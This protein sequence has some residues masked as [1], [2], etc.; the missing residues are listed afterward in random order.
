MNEKIERA[1]NK[2]REDSKNII[3]NMIAGVETKIVYVNGKEYFLNDKEIEVVNT[4]FGTHETAS[5]CCI[6]DID[7]SGICSDCKEHAS[8]VLIFR[9]L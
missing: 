9:N 4:F 2:Y 7:E 6:A 8:K 5:N 3:N 1:L